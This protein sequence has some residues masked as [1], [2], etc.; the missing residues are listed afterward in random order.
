M[1]CYQLIWK[2]PPVGLFVQRAWKRRGLHAHSLQRFAR[3]N[4]SC[5]TRFWQQCDDGW[6]SDSTTRGRW[7]GSRAMQVMF[8]LGLEFALSMAD[9]L[10]PRESRGLA[11]RMT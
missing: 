10:G 6:I 2:M 4:G 11:C 5:D 1:L 3:R 7:Q 8:V 9:D